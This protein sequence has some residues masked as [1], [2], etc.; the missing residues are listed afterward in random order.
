VWQNSRIAYHRGIVEGVLHKILVVR[1][2]GA[3]NQ[4]I[5]SAKFYYQTRIN[6]LK[7]SLRLLVMRLPRASDTASSSSLKT[8]MKAYG[9]AENVEMGRQRMVGGQTYSTI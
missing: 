6:V 5:T 7:C 9:C 8:R 1:P 3:R 2:N 4:Q